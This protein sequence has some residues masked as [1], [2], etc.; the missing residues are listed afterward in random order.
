MFSNK[1]FPDFSKNIRISCLSL[2]YECSVPTVESSIY[3]FQTILVA[4]D[5]TN[6]FYDNGCGDSI[7]TKTCA[8]RLVAKGLATL[9]I[10]GPIDLWGVNNQKSVCVHGIYIIT[11]PFGVG[12]EAKFRAMCLDEI[13]VPFPKYP[14]KGVEDDIRTKVGKTSRAL[15]ATLPRLPSHCGGR[16]DLMIGKPY[17]KYY[18]TEVAKL[19][20]GLTIY[21]AVFDNPDGTK[22]VICGPHPEFTRID[23]LNHFVQPQRFSY[24]SM[25]ARL[26][27]KQA[28]MMMEA[29]L[30]AM[31]AEDRND[32]CECSHQNGLNVYASRTPRCWKKFNQLEST[33][34]EITYR[35]VDCRKCVK[36]KNGPV[37]EEVSIQEEMEQ[38]LVDK[39]VTIDPE[40]R[41][42]TAELPF[43]GDPEK[44]LSPNSH[45]VRKMYDR[46]VRNLARNPKARQEVIDSEAKLQA[47]GFVEWMENLPE[48]DKNM[49]L[50]SVV[51]YHIPWHPV[52]SKSISTPVRIVF[53][54]S[55]KTPSGYSMN[56]LLAL[57]INSMNVL[58]EILIRWATHA[59]AYHADIRKMYNVVR[60]DK[61]YWQY[62]LYYWQKELDP[63]K[64]PSLKVIKTLIYGS[65][66]SGQ[67]AQRAL[68]LTAERSSDKYP[69]AY[70]IVNKDIYVDDCIS[71]SADEALG[72]QD[73]DELQLSVGTGG[74]DWKGF[75]VSGRDPDP[76]LSGGQMFVPV[77]GRKWYPKTDRIM[78]NVSEFAKSTKGGK[79]NVSGIP[80]DITMT[81]CVS[82]VAGIFDPSGLLVPITGGFK[83]DR[84]DL[85]RCNITW[86]DKLPDNLRG[87]WVSNFEMMEEIKTISYSRAV[88]PPDAK[89]LNMETLDMGDASSKLICA[90]IYVRF[91]K[92][93]GSHS[94]QLIFARSKILPDGTT[95]PRG[96]LLAAELNAATGFTVRRALGDRHQ[97]GWKFTDSK[98]AFHWIHC[99]KNVLGT[100]VRNHKINV[101]RLTEL[102]EWQLVESKDM[103]ADIGTRKG[104][105]VA[106]VSEGSSWINGYKWMSGP[107]EEFPM[108]NIDDVKL[109]DQ[110][111]AEANLEKVVLKT[112]YNQTY[113]GFNKNVDELILARYKFSKYVIDPNRFR[114]RKVSRILG[115]VLTFIEKLSNKIGRPTNSKVFSHK[116]PGSLPEYLMCSGDSHLVT[117]G[118]LDESAVFYCPGGKV[119]ILS[120][121]M[122]NCAMNY[123][124]LKTS[125]E[126]QKFQK[127]EKYENITKNL[128]GILYYVGRILDDYHFDGYPELCDAAIDLCRTT[129][130]VPVIDQYSP[131]AISISMEI[132]WHHPDV[133]H[134]GIESM[135]RQSLRVAHILGGRELTKSVKRICARCR[136]MNKNAIGVVMGPLKNVN[137]CIAPAFYPSQLDIC[138]PY[139][140]YSL[141]NKRATVKVWFLVYC[142]CTTGA[143]DIRLLE[144]YSTDAFVLSFIRFSC[145]FGYPKYLLVDSGSQLVKGCENMSYSFTDSKERL[146]MEYGTQYSVCPVG[147]HYVHGKVERKIRE[148]KKSVDIHVH[149]ERL[150]SIQW[151]TLM[152]QISN[153]INNLPIGVKNKVADLENLDLITP[154]RLILGRNNERCPNAPLVL[155]GDHKKL[156]EKNASIFRSWFK[157]WL[158]SYIPSIIERPKWHKNVSDIHV[159]DIVLF[160]K[161]EKDFEEIYQYGIV[162]MVHKGRD[163]LVRKVDVEY[164]NSNEATKRTTQRGV[165]D[166]IVVHPID[167]LDIYERLSPM[168]EDS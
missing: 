123:F 139:K 3:Q 55:H 66:P 112:F 154:N 160:L 73:T 147:A 22:G 12:Q 164:Q 104:A 122:I 138:G 59:W 68:R 7:V 88:V 75:T 144:D 161:S 86:N 30:L 137:L 146:S 42:C 130:C 14:L 142:C 77:G 5:E 143:V 18:P 45:S 35:C 11:V 15:L 152:A 16:V 102:E 38:D 89:S 119:V 134:R 124:Y 99:T 32:V 148:I 109:S 149:N 2:T 156:I 21:E 24:L 34:T 74:F 155:S 79:S 57:G 94:C 116:G 13:T 98:V 113:L 52:T 105:T 140:A 129:F 162:K 106:D 118:L 103:V 93:D 100:F 70:E 48:D 131:V 95:I 78:F 121:K 166:L 36:C 33:G 58:I 9:E 23:R 107:V 27:L 65:R 90:A 80:N 46:Q 97:R 1:K 40:K 19:E 54:C 117:S 84:S 159:G 115:L 133:K 63:N 132:H 62:Q 82:K 28:S 29:P 136:I 91:E 108:K 31:T 67:L 157:A 61:R 125:A 126:V 20:S 81:T 37:I 17:L 50:D 25:D 110:E 151:E 114:F 167:E 158:V 163:D 6:I 60:L 51:K 43:I 49:I 141:V 64:E 145:R 128:D 47:L 26:Y 83:I 85:H 92:R 135:L 53:N 96:E 4:G 41:V 153:S 71:G 111:L 120:D 39:A 168:Y 101:N 56:D 127:L 44:M 87:I 8:D 165:R 76:I 69:R 72:L 150:S 10:P